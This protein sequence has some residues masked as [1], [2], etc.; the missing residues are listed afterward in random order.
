[1]GITT[2]NAAYGNALPRWTINRDGC[3]GSDA[4]KAKTTTYLP[5]DNAGK[6]SNT[7]NPDEYI[8]R[9]CRY[10]ARAF[11][12][13]FAQHTRNGLIGMVFSKPAEVELPSVIEYMKENVDGAGQ[14]LEQ[15]G[16]RLVSEG[17][18][19]GRAGIMADYPNH[20]LDRPTRE[21][22]AKIKASIQYYPAESIQDWDTETKEGVTRLSFVKLAEPY[23]E[24]SADGWTVKET[25][26][27]YRVLRLVNGV[28]TQTLYDKSGAI[29]EPESKPKQNGSTMNHIPFYFIGAENNKPDVDDAPISGIVDCNISHYQNSADLE[30][31]VHVH[32]GSTLIIKTEMSLQSFQEANPNGVSVGANEGLSLGPNGDAKLLQ[33][34][35]DSASSELMQ[36]KERQAEALGAVYATNSDAK[37]VTAEAARINAAQSTSTLTTLVGNVSEA[38][39][40]ALIDCSLFMAGG[41]AVEYSLNQDFHAET[42]DPQFTAM[43]QQGV[44]LEFTSFEEA[45]QLWRDNLGKL[46]FEIE[47][48]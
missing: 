17:I 8:D 41:D 42:L 31:N 29:I 44:D 25:E 33:L 43:L 12:M 21:Q 26:T 1:M 27:R 32:S 38:V 35:A 9:Y 13:P 45:K 16:K 7:N 37:N 22:S 23:S 6:T 40:A 24:R 36:A 28:Y 30:Q 2:V 14:S 18:E 39:Q 11:Y 10:I 5:D 47:S 15:L 46:R 4:I 48:A 34:N 3:K 20:G 19:V